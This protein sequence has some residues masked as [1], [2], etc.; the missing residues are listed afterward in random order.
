MDSVKFDTMILNVVN[1]LVIQGSATM[2]NGSLFLENVD[3]GTME[4]IVF[5][6]NK[7]FGEYF[8]FLVTE[9]PGIS[10]YTVDFR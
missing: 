2:D 1:P 5:D 10:G 3:S 8:G 7:R 6:L 4:G 9:Y